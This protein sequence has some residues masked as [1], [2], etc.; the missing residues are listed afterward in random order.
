MQTKDGGQQQLGLWHKKLRWCKCRSCG[1]R[2]GS[3]INC[4]NIEASASDQS[5][6]E[7]G[8]SD[9]AYH[10]HQPP[11]LSSKGRRT[12]QKLKENQA[13]N[14]ILRLKA[15]LAQQDAQAQEEIQCDYWYN[16]GIAYHDFAELDHQQEASNLRRRVEQLEQVLYGAPYIPILLLVEQVQQLQ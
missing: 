16:E 13:N 4:A 14:E 7:E 11:K 10:G 1:E 3:H 5:G 12:R 15:K 2:H 8:E 6:K 9:A